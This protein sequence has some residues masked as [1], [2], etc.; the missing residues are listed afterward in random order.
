MKLQDIPVAVQDV[1]VQDDSGSESAFTPAL[2]CEIADHLDR[3]L[4][5]GKPAFIDLRSLPMSPSD[6]TDL[7]ESLGQGEVHIVVNALGRSEARETGFP[8]VWWVEHR[9]PDGTR[10][11]EQVEIAGIPQ[12][13][14]AHPEDVQN[15]L[16]RLRDQT[17]PVAATR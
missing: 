13:A 11:A 6:R 14:P 5:T 17:E 9:S 3:F 10:V 1:T 16:Q 8:G 4:K 12:I 15:S 2:L 7:I